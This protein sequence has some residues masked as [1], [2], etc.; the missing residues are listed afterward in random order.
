[1]S[2]DGR[3][4]STSNFEKYRRKLYFPPQVIRCCSKST[5]IDVVVEFI[6]SLWVFRSERVV[7]V[8]IRDR[9]LIGTPKAFCEPYAFHEPCSSSLQDRR[10]VSSVVDEV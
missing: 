10:S 5:Q 8:S 7:W 9:A 3:G 4:F 6:H 2:E 1:M